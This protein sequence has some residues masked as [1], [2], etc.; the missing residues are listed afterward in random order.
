MRKKGVL[1]IFSFV[2]FCLLIF[3]YIC[4][5]FKNH[6]YVSLYY[7]QKSQFYENHEH[8]FFSGYL[9]SWKILKRASE[10]I[11]STKTGA[12]ERSITK[13][14]FISG[15]DSPLKLV[16]ESAYK[17]NKTKSNKKL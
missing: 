9:R 3:S 2:L 5:F 16:K 13:S 15:A 4:H 6:K 14:C 12:R 11:R 1:D 8:L 10:R 7:D 17:D